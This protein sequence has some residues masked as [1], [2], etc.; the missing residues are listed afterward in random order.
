MPASRSRPRSSCQT[1]C[2]S[3]SSARRA[4]LDLRKLLRRRAAVGRDRGD[5]GLGLA[6]QSGDAHR[7]ELVEV[8]RADRDEAQPLQQRVARVLRLLDHAVVEVEPGQFAVD[9]PVR[10]VRPDGELIG[11]WRRIWPIKHIHR[12]VA[13]GQRLPC[14]RFV[15]VAIL[16]ESR[17]VPRGGQRCPGNF[18]RCQ[19]VGQNVGRERHSDVAVLIERRGVQALDRSA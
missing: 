18:I 12:A 9:E 3:A 7:I 13:A 17:V 2:C 16:Q 1:R 14:R 5:A 8:G 10:T 15:H 4:S 11:S 19:L 6:D